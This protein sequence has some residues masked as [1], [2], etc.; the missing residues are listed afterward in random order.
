MTAIAK[1]MSRAFPNSSPEVEVLKG[2][3][4]FCG[5]GLLMS[6]CVASYGVDLSAGFF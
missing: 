4:I 1:V 6:L 3:A 5:L 2:I